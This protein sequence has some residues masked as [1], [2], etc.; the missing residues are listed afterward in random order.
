MNVTFP[1]KVGERCNLS[2]FYCILFLSKKFCFYLINCTELKF[3]IDIFVLLL[4]VVASSEHGL[5]K[6]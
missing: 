5:R 2:L 4:Y 1:G 3:F 6:R